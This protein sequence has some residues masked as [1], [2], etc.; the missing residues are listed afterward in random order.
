MR[1]GGEWIEL[2]PKPAEEKGERIEGIPVLWNFEQKEVIGAVTIF[3]D[4]RTTITLPAG[5]LTARLFDL[6]KQGDLIALSFGF[7][8]VD[9]KET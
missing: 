5:E 3:K 7:A 9:K 6:A 2:I 4:G 8:Q 1:L